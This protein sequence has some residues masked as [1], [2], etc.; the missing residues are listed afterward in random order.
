MDPNLLNSESSDVVLALGTMWGKAPGSSVYDVPFGALQ[1]FTLDTKHTLKELRDP[2]YRTA[3]AVGSVASEV[4]V[5][6]KVAQIRGRALQILVGGSQNYDSG[7]GR[8]TL[9]ITSVN[10]RPT[11]FAIQVHSRNDAA[12]EII[13]TI[14]KCVSEQWSLSLKPEDFVVQD[15]SFKCYGD[16]ANGGALL[17]ISLVGDQTSDSPSTPAAPG[18]VTATAGAG[19]SGLIDLAWATVASANIYSVYRSLSSGAGYVWVGAT[20]SLEFVNKGTTGVHYYYVV[21]AETGSGY[22][23]YSSEVTAVAP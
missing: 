20:A 2:L 21:V 8:T 12:S 4:S 3:A 11:A 10:I 22:S 9:S 16:P 5:K 13:G 23:A 1:D 6:A 19:A 15:P 18:S 17:D 14:Y 7:T